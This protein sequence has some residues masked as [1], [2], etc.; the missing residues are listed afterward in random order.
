MSRTIIHIDVTDFH[1]A[2]ERVL[3]PRLHQ[4]PV[5]IAIEAAGRSLVY[6]ASRE[7]GLNGVY[8]G[9]LLNQALKYC[10]DMTVLPPN[11]E[12]YL[13]ATRA[14][15]G[16]LQQFTPVLEPLRF[17]HAY[18][19]MTG[20]AKL[21]GNAVDAAAKARKEIHDRLRL[22]ATAGVAGNKL[23]SKVA[24]D[25]IT[26][27]DPRAGLCDVHLGEEQRFLSPLQVGYLPGVQKQ[28]RTQLYELNIRLIRELTVIQSEHLQMVFG[29]FGLL[30]YER[31]RGIDNRPVQPPKRS[32]EIVETET[33]AED[34]NDHDRLHTIFFRLLAAS[35]RRLR[36]KKQFTRRLVLEI[37]YSDHKEENGQFK[38]DPAQNDWQMLQP[39]ESL[40]TRTVTRRTRV[41]KMTL[42]LCDL[43]QSYSQLSLFDEAPNPK[44]ESAGKAMDRIRDR[45]GEAAI[46]FGRAS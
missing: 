13:R 10:P 20:S 42:R 23:V 14:L 21:F 36:Q 24:S 5:A 12:L 32:P 45:F 39:A 3:E 7:A 16:I 30:L 34:S 35:T 22:D 26:L 28:V 18:L 25:V 33:L 43:C 46:S 2:V 17:G 19:D 15:M 37:R 1:I 27:R 29:R 38:C 31:S 8:R 44:L 40:L 4:R 6:A 41:R 11:E 9:M